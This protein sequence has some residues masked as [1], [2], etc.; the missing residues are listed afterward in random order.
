[1]NGSA[2]AGGISS[3]SSGN[4]SLAVG[5]DGY[6]VVAWE[7]DGAGTPQKI[8]LR[9]WNGSEW[10]ELAGSATGEGIGVG[11]GPSVAVV[12]A[13]N[14]PIVAWANNS[15]GNWEIYARRWNGSAWVEHLTGS[16]GGGGISDTAG[17]STTPSLAMAGSWA[18]V[19]WDDHSSGEA[20][21]YLRRSAP[22]AAICYFLNLEHD[23]QGA[24]PIAAPANSPGCGTG[25]YSAGQ[26]ISLTAAPFGGWGGIIRWSGTNDDSSTASTN[27]LTMPA[28]NHT[29]RV[30]YEQIPVVTQYLF[31]PAILYQ[32]ATCFPWPD[33]R[34]PNNLQTEANGP[35]CN[36]QTY[37]GRPNDNY[38]VFYFD[39]AAAGPIDIV[40]NN[41]AAGGG[42]LGLLSAD[43]APIVYDVTPGDGFR[44]SRANEPAGRYY[45]V[46]HTPTPDAGAG[47]YTLRVTFP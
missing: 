40:L 18:Y 9:R 47:P 22:I 5:L 2:S 20:E 25:Y 11:W 10:V 12:A 34:E 35:L 44:I 14:W 33:E 36:G 42:Q 45:V 8:Y 43:F 27:S 21:I 4:N 28:H 17:N 38:D 13:P 19:A 24:D 41:F 32:P 31:A 16:A 6:P 7:Y 23:G 1:M 3:G 46:V 29:V 37:H 39:T 15:N 26:A 30:T